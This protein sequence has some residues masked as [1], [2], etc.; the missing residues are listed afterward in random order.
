MA[1]RALSARYLI[2][3]FTLAIGAILAFACG[4]GKDEPTQ[5]KVR[6]NE[7]QFIGTHNS[8]HIQLPKVGID[9]IALFDPGFAQSIEFTH[10]P[11]RSQ[12]DSGIR[13]IELDVYYDPEGGRFAKRMYAEL[14]GLSATE[15]LEELRAPGFKVLHS[16]EIDFFSTCWTLKS[17]LEEILAWSDANP[18]HLPIA[19]FLE[20]KDE[21]T[22]DPLN[23]GI[24]QPLPFDATAVFAMEAE[25]MAVFSRD[26]LVTPDGVRGDRDTLE[27]AV[28]E[29]GWPAVQDT[30]GKVMFVMMDEASKRAA[31]T[32]DAPS[33][34]GRV[35]FT[36]S[37]EG[38]PDAAVV[39]IDDVRGAEDSVQRLVRAG[40]IVRSM[41]DAESV[42]VR[43][44]DTGRRD[45]TF[46][47]GV[48][49][50]ST[51]YP[52]SVGVAAVSGY[53]VRFPD[54]GL[55]RCNPVTASASCAAALSP[56]AR[57]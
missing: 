50:A 46:R 11:L 48:H 25:I 29:D 4:D 33:L 6:L 24:V 21:P 47:A 38:R 13:Q 30:L 3:L 7:L 42:E 10:P 23:I 36:T 9:A 43:A 22:D 45:A 49:Y 44:N 31:Y 20:P 5:P 56:L 54:G 35:M 19:V 15:G 52:Q 32:A 27:Q 41:A 37:S 17:C 12:F 28:L 18:G 34:E 8:Y 55:V 53:V 57:R 1:R 16:P 40:Y 2:V 14:I 26:R 39:K 51:D